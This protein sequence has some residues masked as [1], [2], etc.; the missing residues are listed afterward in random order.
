MGLYHI[1]QVVAQNL[2]QGVQTRFNVIDICSQHREINM[3]QSISPNQIIIELYF[4]VP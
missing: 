1:L 2:T 3:L 4:G